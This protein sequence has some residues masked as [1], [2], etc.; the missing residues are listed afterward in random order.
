MKRIRTAI[1]NWLDR[2]DERWRALPL[3]RQQRY[4][5]YFFAAYL[6]LTAAVFLKIWYDMATSGSR[7]FIEHIHS[8]VRKKEALPPNCT[9]Y[10][11]N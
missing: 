10:Q 11:T 6:L 8:P 7:M 3:H 5:M 9:H 2:Q 4:T 1:S